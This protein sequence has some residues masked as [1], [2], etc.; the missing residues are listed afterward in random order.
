MAIEKMMPLILKNKADR[1]ALQLARSS[2]L[3][4][5]DEVVRQLQ[6]Q[7]AAA[8]LEL[9][10][11]E[12]EIAKLRYEMAKREREEAFAKVPSPSPMMH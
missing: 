6:D 8:R 5:T 7:L 10:Q 1:I 12:V 2:A 11:K 9:S 4:A 3:R